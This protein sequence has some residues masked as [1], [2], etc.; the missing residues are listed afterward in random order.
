M[1]IL[2]DGMSEMLRTIITDI[3]STDPQCEIMADM[4]EQNHLRSQLRETP[5]DVVI[6]AVP[7]VEATSSRCAE[8]LAH[9]PA[10]RIIAI[11]SD[12][13]RALLYDLR[14][15]VTPIDELSPATLLSAIR[16]SPARASGV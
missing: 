4:V 6:L 3:L 7:D 5:A 15:Q 13:K 10:T 16:Q 14:P 1:R 11:T 12:G 9:H 8:L 2:L